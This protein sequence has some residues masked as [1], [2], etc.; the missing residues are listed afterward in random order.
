[1]FNVLLTVGLLDPDRTGAQLVD[2]C[3]SSFARAGADVERLGPVWLR[4]RTHPGLNPQG[5][6]EK[7][8]ALEVFDEE[9][10]T[11]RSLPAVTFSVLIDRRSMTIARANPC[12]GFTRRSSN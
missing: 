7:V 9:A 1:M 10:G 2:A 5:R 6:E 8:D 11:W 4:M 12:G 3:H